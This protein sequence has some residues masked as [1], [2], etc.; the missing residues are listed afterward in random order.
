[1]R[2]SS[3]EIPEIL[4]R[5]LG[6][7]VVVIL[8]IATA[9]VLVGDSLVEKNVLR[10]GSARQSEDIAR[11]NEVM[12]Y[13]A[14][15][16]SAGPTERLTDMAATPL[17]DVTARRALFGVRAERIDLYSLTGVPL[18][19]T[20]Q[21]VI[22]LSGGSIEAFEQAR[23]GATA[24]V[25]RPASAA[26]DVF[27]T[28]RDTLQT[29]ELVLDSP[30]DAAQAGRSLMVAAIST[31]VGDA[32]SS[33]Y[34]TVWMVTV[35]FT[36]GSLL[37]LGVVNWGFVRSR[38]RLERSNNALA[39]QNM[40]VRRSRERMIRASDDT[41]RAI[42][43]ELHGGVQTRLFAAWMK[44]SQTRA[45]L[46]PEAEAAGIELDEIIESLDSIREDDIRGISH[47]LHPS[48]VRIGAAAGLRSL[49]NFYS[50]MI[51]IE[52]QI[53]PSAE[54][55][56]PPG[57]STIPEP[58]RLGVYRIAELALGN[59]VKHAQ[60]SECTVSWR[61][62]AD[63]EQLVLTVTDDGVGFDPAGLTLNGLGMV[64]IHDYADAVG[65]ALELISA[66][67]AGPT[68][69]LSIP[70]TVE[71]TARDLEPI[72]P[73]TSVFAADTSSHVP[74]SG[75]SDTQPRAA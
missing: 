36:L 23:R 40:E 19:T 66:P 58:V 33:A 51:Q 57:L 47:R 35:V 68:V 41:K 28:D 6:V 22:P 10:D 30:P 49:R 42:A 15:G 34:R 7:G 48:I 27:A 62:E 73:F 29:F 46:P 50:E 17:F 67:G 54:E 44:L 43:E 16:L 31:D 70:Y 56:E 4:T 14:L 45:G 55:L 39:A 8:I 18:Y 37:I 71:P 3:L 9:I 20:G 65:G 69:I 12:H 24:S 64:N 1:M 75:I 61:F 38:A 74:Q 11:F 63:R 52:M 59:V 53:D 25:Y 2:R 21:S 13:S 72:T 26:R 60:A 5:P 32:M